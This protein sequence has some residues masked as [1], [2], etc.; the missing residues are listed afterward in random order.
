MIQSGL[1]LLVFLAAGEFLSRKMKAAVPAVLAAGLLFMGACWLGAV[2][3]DMV[4]R[5][6]LTTLAPVIIAMVIVNMGTTTD[7]KQLLANGRVV[8]LA[9]F[10]F[11][12]QLLVLFLAAGLTFGINTAVAGLPG[13]MATNL[14]IQERARSLG[15]DSLV[16]LAVLLFTTQG[17]VSC[18]LVSLMLRKETK[19]LLS[20]R[21]EEK[22]AAGGEPEIPLATEQKKE[23]S[24][25]FR[26]LKLF[27]AAWL[28][29]RVEMFTGIS[30]YVVSLFLGV[31]LGELGFLERGSLE[32]T[33]SGGLMNLMMMAMVLSGFSRATPEMFAQVLLP[34]AAVLI[35][36]V[37]GIF[38]VSRPLGKWLGFSGPMSFAVALNVM[39]G[40]P[41][42]LIISEDVIGYLT[43]DSEEREY[44]LSQ[45]G[46]KMVLGGFTSTTFLA[47]I[48]AGFLVRLMH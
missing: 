11:A 38:L 27:A 39:V 26:F 40:F 16:V 8:A 46:T 13:G 30:R 6:G 1:I 21:E 29:S 3:A 42:N 10:S 43:E 14:I 47:T 34:L 31:L 9:A 4:E 18:P 41:L 20:Q 12:G 22:A 17:L 2:P 44:L 45:I 25:F 37:G 28:A 33:Q 35:C 19:R 7:R 15:Y 24:V 48:A 5:S 32:K 36:E 23:I